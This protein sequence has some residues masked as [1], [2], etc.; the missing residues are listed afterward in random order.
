MLE[1]APESPSNS[2]SLGIEDEVLG[3]D[4]GA[5]V[6]DKATG[7]MF[8]VSSLESNKNESAVPCRDQC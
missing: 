1:D 4:G 5:D 3:I 2:V 8:P 6:I 7:I